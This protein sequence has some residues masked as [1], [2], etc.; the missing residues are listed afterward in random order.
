MAPRI[1]TPNK[2]SPPRPMA[3]PLSDMLVLLHS[4][5]SPGYRTQLGTTSTNKWPKHKMKNLNSHF[6]SLKIFS[7]PPIASAHLLPTYSFLPILWEAAVRWKDGK[8]YKIFPYTKISNFQMSYFTKLKR[9]VIEDENY[10]SGIFS[11]PQRCKGEKLCT[12]LFIYL[13]LTIKP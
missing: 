6:F 11:L 9:W 4:K 3:M 12:N 5:K 10:W 13:G 2:F 8:R 7:T 1:I